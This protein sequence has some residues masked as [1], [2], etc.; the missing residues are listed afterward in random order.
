M[1]TAAD[2]TQ[3]CSSDF[4]GV[5]LIGFFSHDSTQQA[6]EVS[7]FSAAVS[8][9]SHRANLRAVWAEADCRANFASSFDS[10]YTPS[11]TAYFPSKGLYLNLI[12]AFSE[13]QVKAFVDEV[14][15]SA[16]P[17]RAVSVPAAPLDPVRAMEDTCAG[18]AGDGSAEVDAGY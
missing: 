6:K 1:L 11:V 3:H 15:K 14:T 10:S 2:V 8:A 12:G 7:T 5:C 4:K 18:S 16:V 17:A 9:A 13:P